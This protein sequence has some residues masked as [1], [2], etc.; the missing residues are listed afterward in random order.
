VTES[1]KV[2]RVDHLVDRPESVWAQPAAAL[3]LSAASA[4][5]GPIPLAGCPRLVDRA[6]SQK[7]GPDVSLNWDARLTHVGRPPRDAITVDLARPACLQEGGSWPLRSDDR[8]RSRPCGSLSWTFRL[9]SGFAPK[10]SIWIVDGTGTSP[11]RAQLGHVPRWA[12]AFAS[13]EPDQVG[14][15]SRARR[16]SLLFESHL[17]LGCKRTTS[18]VALLLPQ[19][20]GCRRWR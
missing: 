13:A 15:A 20:E 17:H 16:K 8:S 2:D 10:R 6:P 19:Q 11:D 5:R 9:R 12:T 4:P 1:I 7:S 18:T 14:T 3:R